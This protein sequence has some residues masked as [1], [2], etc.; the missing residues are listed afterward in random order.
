MPNLGANP[1]NDG[2]IVRVTMPELTA[3]PTSVR[4]SGVFSEASCASGVG[5]P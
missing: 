1:S 3:E 4:A 2:N 5:E